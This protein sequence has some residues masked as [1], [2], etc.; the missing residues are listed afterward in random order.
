[1]IIKKNDK[2]SNFTVRRVRNY[3]YR[4]RS[5]CD[6]LEQTIKR[7]SPTPPCSEPAEVTEMFASLDWVKKLHFYICSSK[8]NLTSSTS[9]LR[10]ISHAGTQKL[11]RRGLGENCR[12][13]EKNRR[14]II[15]MKGGNVPAVAQS[16]TGL[17]KTTASD[18]SVGRIDSSRL[19]PR[20]GSAPLPWTRGLGP[21]PH[22][23]PASV[24]A[25]SS[26]QSGPAEPVRTGASPLSHRFHTDF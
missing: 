3:F 21:E 10:F 19:G 9:F 15:P 4:F 26:R 11:S 13:Q 14:G 23:I 1:M 18:G 25:A 17:K 6:E 20:H 2:S 8:K 24:S 22:L 5:V 7:A 16:R 12:K